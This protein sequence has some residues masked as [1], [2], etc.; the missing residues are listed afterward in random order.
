MTTLRTTVQL[1][2]DEGIVQLE[3]GGLT[4]RRVACDPDDR[5]SLDVCHLLVDH[6]LALGVGV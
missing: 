6:L 1:I 5:D 2:D 3:L 4:L